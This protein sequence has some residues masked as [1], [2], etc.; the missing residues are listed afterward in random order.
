MTCESSTGSVNADQ[1]DPNLL[2]SWEITISGKSGI[3]L[4]AN[5][6]MFSL[7]ASLRA[8]SAAYGA[9]PQIRRAR[10]D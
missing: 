2:V 10:S 5:K 6:A 7:V 8:G 3:S 9:T 4:A 1:F